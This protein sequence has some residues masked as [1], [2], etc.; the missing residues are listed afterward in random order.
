MY[1]TVFFHTISRAVKT[2]ARC[3]LAL[4]PGIMSIL[5]MLSPAHAATITI[6][7]MLDR[8]VSLDH[9]AQR[10]VLS[11]GRHILTLGLLDRDPTARLVAWG[12]DL[13]RYS[14]TTYQALIAKFP[15]AQKIPTVGS[16]SGGSFSMES[17]IAAKPDLVIFTLYGPKPDGLQKLDA[18]GIAYVFVDFFRQPLKNT[19]PSL[20]ILGK[21]LGREDRANAFITFYEQHMATLAKD[22]EGVRRPSVLFH[23]NPDGKTCCFS[24]GQGN[25][26]DFIAAA[27]GR[28]IGADVIPGAIGR[29]SLESI[30][31]RRP[32]FYLAGGGST[33][34]LNGLKIGPS[35]K[36]SAATHSLASIM[37]TPGLSHLSAIQRRQAGG[38]WLF[39]F[40]N[41][42]FFVGVEGIANMLHPDLQADISAKQTLQ[43]LNDRFL[44]FPLTGTFW[45][46]AEAGTS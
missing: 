6:T 27:G 37:S 10:I 34:A 33:V 18:A 2:A 36:K 8:T 14:P 46:K 17:V 19:A 4:L 35:I 24:A 25:M 21:L 40:D 12:N 11:E 44:A 13:Q 31:S 22:L 26:T 38:I 7:D 23:L 28:N 1:Q 9:P 32:D 41:P 30:L 20:R 5:L 29:L 3:T 16:L 15:S 45:I 39:F 43:T 42:L